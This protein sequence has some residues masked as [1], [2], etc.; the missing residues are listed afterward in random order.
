PRPR[1]RRLPRLRQPPA[2]L[3][4]PGGARKAGIAGSNAQ[5]L[6]RILANEDG[7]QRTDVVD[8]RRRQLLETEGSG[9]EARGPGVREVGQRAGGGKV[10]EEAQG[11]EVLAEQRLPV[12][13]IEV[14]AL[15]RPPLQALV[16]GEGLAVEDGRQRGDEGAAGLQVALPVGEGGAG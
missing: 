5:R 9:I 2:R 6:G 12:P 16:E 15:A 10:A 7:R 1:P 3:R 8:L 4:R 11:S 13:E 14:R